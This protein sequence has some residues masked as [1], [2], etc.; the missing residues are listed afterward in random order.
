MLRLIFGIAVLGFMSF[1]NAY[2]DQQV[3]VVCDPN[4]HEV[5]VITPDKDDVYQQTTMIVP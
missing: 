2:A 4:C 1:N 3:V 5:I